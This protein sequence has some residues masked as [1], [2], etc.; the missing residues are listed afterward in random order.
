MADADTSYPGVVNVR[1]V[2]VCAIWLGFVFVLDLPRVMAV[3]GVV[4]AFLFAWWHER[5]EVAAPADE[6]DHCDQV[7]YE[8]E[9][10]FERDP[11]FYA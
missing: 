5:K 9:E 7:E 3:A 6:V 10:P 2:L 11:V 4:F 8:D 1:A